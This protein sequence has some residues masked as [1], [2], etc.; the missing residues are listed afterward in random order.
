MCKEFNSVQS[1]PSSM[2]VFEPDLVDLTSQLC[3][4]YSDDF[5]SDF[6]RLIIDARL[7]WVLQR[8]RSGRS[9]R[10]LEDPVQVRQVG[11]CLIV[12]AI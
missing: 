11:S 8:M 12:T 1:Q 9:W 2:F 10:Y 6:Y 5:K 3:P 4:M 7:L